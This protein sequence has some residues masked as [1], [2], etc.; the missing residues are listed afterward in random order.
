MKVHTNPNCLSADAQECIYTP[1]IPLIKAN[2]E[3]EKGFDIINIKIFWNP[4]SSASET[5]KLKVATLEN[6][7][8]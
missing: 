8:P 5:Y 1:L 6:G 3:D 7:K 2:T 4:E